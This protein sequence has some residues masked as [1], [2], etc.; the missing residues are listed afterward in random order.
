MLYGGVGV[1]MGYEMIYGFDV[2]GMFLEI[3]LYLWLNVRRLWV[4]VVN[5]ISK[6]LL[7]RY[8]GFCMMV[9]S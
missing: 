3:C 7:K 9:I 4:I 2:N 8:W 5:K 1:I 6:M